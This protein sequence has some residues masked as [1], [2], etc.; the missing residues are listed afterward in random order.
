M[1]GC[2]APD[3]QI[4]MAQLSAKYYYGLPPGKEQPRVQLPVT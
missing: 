4:A 2:V 1:Y 3:T